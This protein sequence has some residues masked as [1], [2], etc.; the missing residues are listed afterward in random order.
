MNDQDLD[1]LS[2]EELKSEILK[3]RNGIRNHRDSSGHNLCWF[4]PELWDLLPEKITPNPVVPLTEEFLHN[5]K[6]Y[7][8]S[9]DKCNLTGK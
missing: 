7:R 3:L 4:V 6:L 2:I 8:I 1:D 5:C 9:L